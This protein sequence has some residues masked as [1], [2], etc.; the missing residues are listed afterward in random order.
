MKVNN[1]CFLVL[2][3]LKS[4]I[5][6]K[7]NMAYIC[8]ICIYIGIIRIY[9]QS[10]NLSQPLQ[11]HHFQHCLNGRTRISTNFIHLPI[12]NSVDK[13]P[14]PRLYSFQVLSWNLIW[15]ENRRWKT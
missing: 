15:L 4:F 12:Q 1:R 13:S 7:R 14:N 2:K 8:M 3:G 6:K 5:P 9:G 10:R 11:P